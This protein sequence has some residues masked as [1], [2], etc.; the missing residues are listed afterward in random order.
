MG[1][2]EIAEEYDNVHAIIHPL[3]YEP[4]CR[5]IERIIRSSIHQGTI[6]QESGNAML[7][8]E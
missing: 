3:I 5:M 4:R 6:T 2:E 7:A 8:R 1:M